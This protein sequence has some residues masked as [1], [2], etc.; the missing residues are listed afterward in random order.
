MFI[1]GG[2]WCCVLLTVTVC[3]VT[4]GFR[5]IFTSCLRLLYLSCFCNAQTVRPST[6]LVARF[7][8]ACVD[9]TEGGEAAPPLPPPSSQY[10]RNSCSCPCCFGACS[11]QHTVTPGSLTSLALK[12]LLYRAFRKQYLPAQN[13][14]C[15]VC[16]SA[17]IIFVQKAVA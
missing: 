17:S 2:M 3:P 4:V 5:D 14:T 13:R 16:Q 7:L 15:H 12:G 10:Q 6:V 1:V 8:P 11:V 9:S